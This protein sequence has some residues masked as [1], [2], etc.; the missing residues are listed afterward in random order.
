MVI[1]VRQVRHFN[2]N[3]K[4]KFQQKQNQKSGNL[5][6]DKLREKKLKNMI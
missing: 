2:E 4:K 5:N 1:L 3:Q 6:R